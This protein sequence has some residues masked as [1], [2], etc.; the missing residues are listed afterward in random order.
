MKKNWQSVS[1]VHSIE[2]RIG[3]SRSTSFGNQIPDAFIRCAFR[4]WKKMIVTKAPCCFQ[5]FH[6][7]IKSSLRLVSNDIDGCHK[8]GLNQNWRKQDCI[9]W[10]KDHMTWQSDRCRTAH[11]QTHKS[12]AALR[13]KNA[14]SAIKPFSVAHETRRRA[15]S[16]IRVY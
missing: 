15:D 6:L 13:R 14:Q 8:R 4:I 9:V 2:S 12:H 16:R 11:S 7:L 5:Y 3:H 1:F 10:R